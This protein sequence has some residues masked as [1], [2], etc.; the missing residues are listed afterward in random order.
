MSDEPTEPQAGTGLA[1]ELL[2]VAKQA[3]EAGAEVLIK[4]DA[5]PNRPNRFDVVIEEEG[6]YGGQCGEFCGLLHSRQLFEIDA[7][8]RASFDAWLT[9]QAER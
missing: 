2:H 1:A 3:A 6:T 4:R 8:S 5:V 7:V 9:G